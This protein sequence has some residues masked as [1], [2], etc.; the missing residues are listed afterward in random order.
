MKLSEMIQFVLDKAQLPSGDRRIENIVKTALNTA[1]I[2]FA[3]VDC[4]LTEYEIDAPIQMIT[5][6]PFD[7]LTPLQVF[8]GFLGSLNDYQYRVSNTNLVVAKHVANYDTTSKMTLLY[9]RRPDLLVLEDDE[10]VI[11]E[12]YHMGLCYYALTEITEDAQYRYKYETLITSVPPFEPLLNDNLIE[13]Y[14]RD[15]YI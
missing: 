1:Y 4:D 12:E 7:H 2:N 6:L 3:R 15:S 14:V 10:P 11:K 5:P 13:E 8:H 9:G